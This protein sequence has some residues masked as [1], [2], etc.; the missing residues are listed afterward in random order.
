MYPAEQPKLLFE[1]TLFE[2]HYEAHESKRVEGEADYTMVGHKGHQLRFG[3]YY[4]LHNDSLRT[5]DKR[6][7]AQVVP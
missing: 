7:A 6:E 4:V 5:I 1:V 3:E 2:R